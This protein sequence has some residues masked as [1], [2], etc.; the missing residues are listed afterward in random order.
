[1]TEQQEREMDQD[2]RAFEAEDRVRIGTTWGLL[3]LIERDA[4]YRDMC[5]AIKRHLSGTR[6]L[7]GLCPKEESDGR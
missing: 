5:L 7:N 2:Y 1:M 6:A 3:S 4:D